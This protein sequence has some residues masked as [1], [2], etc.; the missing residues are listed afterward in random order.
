MCRVAAIFDRNTSPAQAWRV[1]LQNDRITW[2]ARAGTLPA[3]HLRDP[4]TSAWRR[5]LQSIY[6]LLAPESLL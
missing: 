3:G 4:D 2:I 1:T 5:L 6:G